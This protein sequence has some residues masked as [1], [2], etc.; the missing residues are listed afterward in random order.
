M[1][2]FV[3]CDG[4]KFAFY[5]THITHGLTI[6]ASAAALACYQLMPGTRAVFIVLIQFK[7]PTDARCTNLLVLFVT[8]AVG[9]IIGNRRKNKQENCQFSV[10]EKNCD[11]ATATLACDDVTLRDVVTSTTAKRCRLTPNL[12]DKSVGTS[13]VADVRSHVSKL[14]SKVTKLTGRTPHR[15]IVQLTVVTCRRASRCDIARCVAVVTS[16]RRAAFGSSRHRIIH[17]RRLRPLRHAGCVGLL[18]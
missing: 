17:G 14:V 5:Q 12:P 8:T 1:K 4:P 18:T 11:V 7:L 13:A 16:V 3:F 6:L 10:P 15:W 9:R 2:G